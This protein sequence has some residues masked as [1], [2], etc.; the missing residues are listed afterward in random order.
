M[1]E[2]ENATTHLL[3][4]LIEAQIFNLLLERW[5]DFWKKEEKSS[6]HILQLL[7]LHNK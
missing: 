7:K 2:P 1:K 3:K 6:M 4:T 5:I